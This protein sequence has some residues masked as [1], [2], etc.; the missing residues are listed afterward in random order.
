MGRHWVESCVSRGRLIPEGVDTDIL[1][2]EG[3]EGGAGGGTAGDDLWRK[4]P[5]RGN[6]RGMSRGV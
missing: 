4:G 5:G 2:A 1:H 6:G 3:V